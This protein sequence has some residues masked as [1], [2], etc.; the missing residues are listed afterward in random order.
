MALQV[1][2]HQLVSPQRVLLQAWRCAIQPGQI[3]TLMG[4]SGCGKSSLLQAIA[5]L[6]P[7]GF[8]WRGNCTLHG[9]SLDDLPTHKRRV[10]LLFQEDRLFE[11]MSV[12]DNLSYATPTGSAAARRDAIRAA[13][14][15]IE[16]EHIADAL[17][18]QLSGG[19]RAR[20]ALMRT[21]L[22]QPHAVLLDEPFSALDERL[23][24]R[25][26]VKVFDLL[27]ASA[28]PVLL[29][30]HDPQDIADPQALMQWPETDARH[31]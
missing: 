10:G 30:T 27:R 11:H 22:A 19:Q 24:E 2:V 16:L 1:N 26:R 13:L 29:V 5:G 18:A 20:V 4:P 3:M 7:S 25:V 8:E 9:Q 28:I 12:Q 17:P 21:L 6:L 14:N 31:V 15:A 23:R